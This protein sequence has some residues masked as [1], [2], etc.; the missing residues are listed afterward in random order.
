MKNE[1]IMYY[2]NM[3]SNF[4]LNL[5]GVHFNFPLCIIF[6]KMSKWYIDQYSIN[7]I[8]E[9]LGNSEFKTRELIP[10]PASGQ[11][12]CRTLLYS[13]STHENFIFP[14]EEESLEGYLNPSSGIINPWKDI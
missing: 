2:F 7:I 13:T 4:R 1:K 8:A 12:Q 10:V 11:N 14:D 3:I 5:S 6:S 9:N